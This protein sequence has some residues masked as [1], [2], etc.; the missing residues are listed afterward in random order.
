[1]SRGL[2]A[3]SCAVIWAAGLGGCTALQCSPENCATD[4]EIIEDVKALFAEHP[5]FGPPVGIHVQSINGVVYLTG[6]VSTDFLRQNAD[7]LVRQ[8]P[9]VKDVVNSLYPDNGAY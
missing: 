9:N 8:V 6:K 5:E 7:A 2:L 4:A 1:M 3:L